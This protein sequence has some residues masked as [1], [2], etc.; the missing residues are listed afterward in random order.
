MPLGLVLACGAPERGS[1]RP[2]IVVYVIDTLRADH[3]GAYGYDRNTSPAL[4]RLASQSILFERAYSPAPWTLPSVVS[5]LTS[6]PPCEHQV[7]L[8]RRQ[9]AP[10]VATWAERIRAQGYRTV[11]FHANPYAGRASGLHRGFDL[12]AQLGPGRQSVSG[13]L[14]PLPS[15]PL[16]LYLHSVEP[17]DPYETSP[18][19]VPEATI[20]EVGDRRRNGINRLLTR[21]RQ[22]TRVDWAE[23]RP[24]GTTD[25]TADQ[26]AVMKNLQKLR[27]TVL[28]LYDTDIRIAD[29]N[30]ASVILALQE[31]GI[32]DQTIFVV[33]SDHGEAFG[34]HLGWQHDQSLYEEL[35]HVPLLIR[36]PG[37]RMAGR[38]L[39]QPVSLLDLLPTVVDAAGLEEIADEGPGRSWW[40]WLEGAGDPPSE[41]VRVVRENLKKHY[42]PFKR[43]RGDRN[44]ALVEDGWKAIW[45]DE[46]GTVELYDL[47]RDP[48]ERDDVSER[49]PERARAM[50]E[51]ARDW[52]A[53][54]GDGAVRPTEDG[55]LDED[56]LERLR[57]L[58]YVD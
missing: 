55:D 50:A 51:S 41:P 14:D 38:R 9:L 21:Y 48:D 28:G 36:L 56:S 35:V 54:C 32:W 46:P 20:P 15:Q 29:V 1:P 10:G 34:E 37:N 13:L 47:A 44:V 33:T 6:L 4:D 18:V 40:P 58:G 19:L 17:H 25:T 16:F 49:E 43:E 12:V 52:L 22:L 30:L 5:I 39:Q 11:N 3:L 27:Q 31:A 8:D 42:A 57:A 45:N 2:H 26:D 53:R 7:L 23:G 24:P